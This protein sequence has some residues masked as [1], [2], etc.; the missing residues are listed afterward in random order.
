MSIR[1]KNWFTSKTVQIM[2]LLGK[3]SLCNRMNI[4]SD[5]PTWILYRSK[6]PSTETIP[7]QLQEN[8]M[9]QENIPGIL[10]EVSKLKCLPKV[11]TLTLEINTFL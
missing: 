10:T 3:Y 9:A 6:K 11:T 7:T 1:Y 4:F 5:L 2:K 8:P